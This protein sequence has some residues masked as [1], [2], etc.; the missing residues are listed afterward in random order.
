MT[1]NWSLW[2]RSQMRKK[3]KV[4]HPI[5][6]PTWCTTR[7]MSQHK[8]K[9]FNTA[10]IHIHF[11]FLSMSSATHIVQDQAGIHAYFIAFYTPLN[12]S[13]VGFRGTNA[14]FEMLTNSVLAQVL[15]KDKKK[16]VK[17]FMHIVAKYFN[18][19]QNPYF[20]FWKNKGSATLMVQ[21][22]PAGDTNSSNSTATMNIARSYTPAAT[23]L[24][25]A[26]T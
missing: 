11:F 10:H 7:T 18:M 9:T 25:T 21:S 24:V 3:K 17:M 6:M 19:P 13:N 26:S 20:L 23:F 1:H 5:E 8:Q 2:L 22:F 12:L 16:F 14:G 15:R 4:Q